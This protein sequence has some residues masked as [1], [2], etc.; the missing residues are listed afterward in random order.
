MNREDGGEE[1]S[2]LI[3]LVRSGDWEDQDT[4]SL[5]DTFFTR[6]KLKPSDPNEYAVAS[7]HFQGT[8]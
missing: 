6:P 8:F 7:T 4:K 1:G 3:G 5:V 2:R